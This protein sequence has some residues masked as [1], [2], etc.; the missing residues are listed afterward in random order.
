MVVRLPGPWHIDPGFAPNF[1]EIA[2][3]IE[4]FRGILHVYNHTKRW[5]LLVPGTLQGCQEKC[6]EHFRSWS[7]CRFQPQIDSQ[8]DADIFK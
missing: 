5:Q 8:N 1:P 6:S 2:L 4:L 7:H 3:R